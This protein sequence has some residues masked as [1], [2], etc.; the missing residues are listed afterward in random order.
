MKDFESFNI[1]ADRTNVSVFWA[2]APLAEA[3]G[4]GMHQYKD[5]VGQD[6]FLHTSYHGGATFRDKHH[7]I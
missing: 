6:T 5:R 4:Q 7:K 1:K 2:P 3:K